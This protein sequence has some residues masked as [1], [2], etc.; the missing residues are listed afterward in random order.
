[1]RLSGALGWLRAKD[2]GLTSTKRAVRV[3]VAACLGFYVCR[4][5]LG[6]STMATYAIFGTLAFGALSEVTG[7]PAE[8]TRILLRCLGI[9]VGLVTLGTF[10]AV[11][12]WAASA[13]MAV[14]GF[15][16]A[17]AG[18]GGPRFTGV[19]NGL[20]LLYILPCFPPFA[21]D[22]LPHRLI[23][24]AIGVGL[25]ILVD[26]LLWPAPAPRTFQ[27]RL[28][29]VSGLVAAQSRA[30]S[31]VLE[32][33]RAGADPVDAE[34]RRELADRQADAAAGVDQLRP[35]HLPAQQ[36]PAGPGTV[37][38][39]LTHAAT[40]IRGL[41][42]RLAALTD[43]ITDADPAGIPKGT[44]DLL[45]AVG[46][47][48]EVVCA[49]LA[50]TGPAPAAEPLEAAIAAHTENRLRE[51]TGAPSTTDLSTWAR[52]GVEAT[53]AA[54]TT[55]TL[56]LATRAVLDAPEPPSARAETTPNG[57]FWYAGASAPVLWW[58]R[59][60]GNLT[61]RSVY[62]QN[63]IRLAIGLA[64]ARLIAGEL[65]L[66]HGFWVLLAVLTVMRTSVVAT[67]VA[68]LP[69]LGG[70]LVGAVAV[71]GIV[72]IQPGPIWFAVLLP[73][74]L[75]LALLSASALG[76]GV[77]QCFFT[78]T[79]ALVFAQ[80]APIDARLGSMRLVDVLLG[81]L[82]GLLAGIVAWPRGGRGEVRRAAATCLSEAADYLEYA[83]NRLAFGIGAN[84]AKDPGPAVRHL[85]RLFD[86]TLAQYSS[87]RTTPRDDPIAWLTVLTA[88]HRVSRGATVLLHRYPSPDPL[89]WPS[90]ADELRDEGIRV[91]RGYR[92]VA[93]ALRQGGPLAPPDVGP[94]FARGPGD[95]LVDTAARDG[96]GDPH[97]AMRMLDAWGWFSW[98]IHDL[99]RLDHVATGAR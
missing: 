23:G 45:R 31:A 28:A 80:L 19:A 8:R 83:A 1:M 96:A 4:Y 54:D 88:A 34:L 9:G 78:I 89:P 97:A 59:L 69:A 81:G 42:V 35:I 40:A 10:L 53:E 12:S 24:L 98:L 51:L 62:L 66:Y 55:R 50:G 73:I 3:T 33:R 86:T 30:L 75:F 58:R 32:A 67:G 64:V 36:R 92:H 22:T 74:S 91:A 26:R 99:A 29:E 7:E 20:Q 60:K 21:P 90:A 70:T 6:Q 14:V 72:V 27:S 43:L 63:A 46:D 16:V 56:V 94:G 61:L 57:A 39:G 38:R 47:A 17:F 49:A 41:H 68:L 5:G 52:L 77:G 48:L 11:S 85:V 13:G 18:V 82:V 79:I 84:G 76:L 37:D 44:Q 65:D 93:S 95:E 15:A 25:V 71:T 2:E 87:E